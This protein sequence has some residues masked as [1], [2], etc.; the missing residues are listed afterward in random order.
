MKMLESFLGKS[1][2]RSILL[3]GIAVTVGIHPYLAKPLQ[4]LL[5]GKFPLS[6]LLIVTLEIAF[7]GLVFSSGY[8][9]IFYLFEGFAIP[10]ALQWRERHWRQQ[11]ARWT[12]ELKDL[13]ER[14]TELSRHEILR[15]RRLTERILDF[16]MQRSAGGL[17]PY[18]SSPTL[19]GNIIASFEDYPRTRYG[20][21]GEHYWF[22][23]LYLAPSTGVA[24]FNEKS[25]SADSLL[26]ACFG[27]Q[28][29]ALVQ[30]MFLLLCLVG[31]L[32]P[33]ESLIVSP[34]SVH[35]ATAL[36]VSST[37][38]AWIFYKMALPAFRD[39]GRSASA[40]IDI[41]VPDLT[42]FIEKT[43]VPPTDR[44]REKSDRFRLFS[45]FNRVPVSTP[46]DGEPVSH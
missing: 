25:D 26:L 44:L 6:D 18:V 41:T 2:I 13:E 37:L 3:P 21:S 4:A 30:A 35:L 23:L 5:G 11:L 38:M 8:R 29:V 9:G 34:V 7:F 42:D 43:E 27:W 32:L 39:L 45:R 31:T 14:R 15:A 46:D 28:I 19:L 36:L 17:E 40:L 12:S 20:L 10:R 1:R 22:H 24:E 16:P 33:K